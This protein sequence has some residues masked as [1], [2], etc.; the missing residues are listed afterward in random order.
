MNDIYCHS[1]YSKQKAKRNEKIGNHKR[2]T[3]LESLWTH[4][5]TPDEP[6]SEWPLKNIDT[7]FQCQWNILLHT[8]Q[9]LIQI[10]EKGWVF[11]KLFGKLKKLISHRPMVETV[12][13]LRRDREIFCL[14]TKEHTDKS[15]ITPIF[16]S[17]S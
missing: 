14:V 3:L 1:E 15:L 5:E 9:Q 17:F 16:G 12:L 4:I 10:Q 6:D 11:D 13:K 2:G 7:S 8:V